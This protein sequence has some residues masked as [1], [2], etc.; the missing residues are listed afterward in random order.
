MYPGRGDT[1]T[2]DT[3]DYLNTGIQAEYK[4]KAVRRIEGVGKVTG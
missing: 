2:G 4:D 3:K 1:S